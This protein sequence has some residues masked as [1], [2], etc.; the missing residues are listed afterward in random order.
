MTQQNPTQPPLQDQ[1]PPPHQQPVEP[2]PDQDPPIP[3]KRAGWIASH[4][5][6]TAVLIAVGLAVV[7]GVGVAAIS[8][9][10][11]GTN[12]APETTAIQNAAESCSVAPM[13][14]D[15]GRSLELATRPGGSASI[16]D[17]ACI[18]LALDIPDAMVT[19]IDNTNSLMGMQEDSWDA[20]TASWAYH[21]DN[22]LLLI[23]EER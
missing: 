5:V 10:A 4:K 16:A 8:G 12:E 14:G 22:G 19:R 20:F 2:S 13:V 17:V 23:I 11:G 15:D 1:Q 6:L 9:S 3:P 7:G 21:P 18:S